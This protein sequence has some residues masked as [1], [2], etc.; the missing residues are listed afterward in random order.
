[1][2]LDECSYER[3]LRAIKALMESLPPNWEP[4]GRALVVQD[5]RP[6]DG[7]RSARPGVRG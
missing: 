5:V 1:M 7:S 6:N 2:G 3:Q 4:A